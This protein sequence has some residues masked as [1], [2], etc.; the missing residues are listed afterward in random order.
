MLSFFSSSNGIVSSSKAIQVCLE[1]ALKDEN[2]LD[3][4]LLVIHSTIGHNFQQILNKA[5][6]LS[7]SAKIVGC[8]CAGIIGHEGANENMRALAIMA[9]KTD[10]KKDFCV[11]S[12]ENIRG[13]NSYDV[14]KQ[15]EEDLK[16]QN[17]AINMIQILASGIDIAA[18]RAIEGIE[19]VFGKEIPIFGG[20]S[21]DNMK[22]VSSYQFIDTTVLERGAVL[23]GYADP[24]LEVVMGVHHGSI[25]I[26]MGFKVTKAE[27]NRVRLV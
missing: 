1:D 25:P 19:A 24:N 15:M 23:V 13:A 5:R 26:G 21:S 9:I 16:A 8:T 12:C 20:T 6:E 11:A 2:S 10:T 4:N 22:A 18:D 14:A 17:P 3:C 27:K 7:P